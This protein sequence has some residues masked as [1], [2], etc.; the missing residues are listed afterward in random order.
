MDIES[1]ERN[2]DRSID[3]LSERLG[4]LKQVSGHDHMQHSEHTNIRGAI[5]E[6]AQQLF[7]SQPTPHTPRMC[8]N[9]S[10]KGTCSSSIIGVVLQR[11]IWRL[12]SLLPCLC[13]AHCSSHHQGMQKLRQAV[14]HGS[15]IVNVSA[16][17]MMKTEPELVG[18]TLCY[19][20][21]VLDNTQA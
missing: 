10:W 3:A 15:Y 4:L 16:S 7:K 2:N 18:E 12:P 1:L 20:N 8:S 14:A 17:C 6:L 11:H 9:S 21:T 13:A 5:R 19:H